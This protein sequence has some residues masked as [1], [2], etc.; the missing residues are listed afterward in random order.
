MKLLELFKTLSLSPS[1]TEELKGLIFQL[2]IQGKLTLKWREK[3]PNIE[4]AHE[5]LKYIHAERISLPNGK[6]TK[7]SEPISNS[8]KYFIIPKTWEWERL[9]NIGKI[10]NGNSINKTVKETKY[11]ILT[12]GY[13][14]VATKDVNYCFEKINSNTGVKIPFN[15]PKFKIGKKGTVLICS[16]GG[17]AGKKMG[18]LREDSFFGNKLFALEQ[19][20]KVESNYIMALYGSHSFNYAFSNK[21]TG[22]IGGISKNNFSK[23]LIPIPPYEEQIAIVEIVK[24]LLHEVEQLEALSQQRI[25][26]KENFVESALGKLTSSEDTS[27]E[28]NYLAPHFKKFFTEKKSVKLLRE[29][30]L[31]IAVQGKLTKKWREENPNVEPASE[32]LKR[33]GEKKQQLI[34]EKKSKKEKLLPCIEAS[35]IPYE[36]PISWEWERLNNVTKLITKGSSPKWQ[37][38][39]YVNESDGGVLFITSEN[40]GNYNLI[41]K[42]KKFVEVKFNDIEPRS[43]LRKNDILMNIVGGSIGRTAIYNLEEIANINQA[44]TIIRLI[45][46]QDHNY[47]LHFF[48][49]PVCVSYMYDKQVDNARP[50]LSM[51]N[52]AKFVIPIPPLEEQKAIVEKV[53]SLMALCDELEKQ[54]INSETQIEL[55]MKSCLKEALE[56]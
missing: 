33:I 51:G 5:L 10:F 34:K 35:E 11:S 43:I 18:I 28:W 52:I 50:N 14:Y 27:Q 23:L 46:N 16:E 42:K 3:H 8:E 49:S 13:Q 12:E 30:I 1:N 21:M 9:G 26:L 39:Q 19:Y 48:N 53:S 15:E 32:L 29:T 47:F 4:P 17:S 25:K 56:I 22:I 38:I 36:L 2:A 37:G 6:R 24:E 44:V 55:L 40:V 41:L 45:D 31:Q 7:F 20:G 54:I